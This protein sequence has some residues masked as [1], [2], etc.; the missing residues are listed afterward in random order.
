MILATAAFKRARRRRRNIWRTWLRNSSCS[1]GAPSSSDC[2]S[3]WTWFGGKPNPPRFEGGVIEERRS[4][5]SESFR[6]A[7]PHP[8]DSGRASG[9][10]RPHDRMQSGRALLRFTFLL[11]LCATRRPLRA[12]TLYPPV[13]LIWRATA[14]AVRPRPMTKSW[15]LGLRAIA[16]SRASCK[17]SSEA[18]AR[19]GARRSAA[20]SWPRHM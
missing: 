18:E 15:P 6:P 16:A 3:F 2:R 19:R 20:S 8:R 11:L 13:T 9:A 10:S 5:R 17:S 4:L 7:R 12:R 1:Q 14:G